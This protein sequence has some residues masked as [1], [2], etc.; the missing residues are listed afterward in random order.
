MSS[1]IFVGG[2]FIATGM[3]CALGFSVGLCRQGSGRVG[4]IERI[5]EEIGTS[6]TAEVILV[7]KMSK[8]NKTAAAAVRYKT[9]LSEKCDLFL[10]LL[11]PEGLVMP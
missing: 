3:V 4:R 11:L 7:E 1:S 5:A 2:F 8:T 6:N 10:L 9:H